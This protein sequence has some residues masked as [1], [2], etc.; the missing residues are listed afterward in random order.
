[1][2]VAIVTG[3][4]GGLGQGITEALLRDQ[5]SVCMLDVSE[6]RGTAAAK[7]L[8]EVHGEERVLFV[9]CDITK[10][11]EYEAAWSTCEEKL[12]TPSLLV[13]NAGVLDE[14]NP[15]K[16]VDVNV[17]A[18]IHGTTIAQ[19]RMRRDGEREGGVVLNVASSTGLC[20]FPLTPVYAA[21]KHA[22]VGLS[23]SYGHPTQFAATGVKVL[24][25][26]PGGFLTPLLINRPNLNP[27][28]DARGL[29]GLNPMKVEEIAAAAMRLLKEG[30]NGAV[31]VLEKGNEPH[32]HTEPRV[33]HGFYRKDGTVE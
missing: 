12:G 25:L 33:D 4:A 23:T 18:V 29:Y 17:M 31:M 9:L 22:V 6:E 11:H 13:N 5:Y 3:A 14:A 16:M 20:G 21:T 28:L 8:A 1:M 27:D 10:K 15:Q 24:C 32:Y 26:C 30:K 2:S 19:K 7:K